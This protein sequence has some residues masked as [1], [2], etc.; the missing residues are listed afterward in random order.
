[1]T[2]CV[3][4]NY[5]T[6]PQE[7]IEVTSQL[8]QEKNKFVIHEELRDIVDFKTFF[9]DVRH[10]LV[11]LGTQRAQQSAGRSVHALRVTLAK[12][13]MPCLQYKE[14]DCTG[15][16][17]MGHFRDSDRP[18]EIFKSLNFPSEFTVHHRR[19]IT[20]IDKIEEKWIAFAKFLNVDQGNPDQDP[21][22]TLH[23]TAVRA[24]KFWTNMFEEHARYWAT[25]PDID[26]HQACRPVYPDGYKYV[27]PRVS[28]TTLEK[29]QAQ[30]SYIKAAKLLHLV[31]HCSQDLVDDHAEFLGDIH[32]DLLQAFKRAAVANDVVSERLNH[33]ATTSPL[34]IMHK[35]DK[36][37]DRTIFNPEAHTKTGD[38]VLL[39]LR[40]DEHAVKG[41]ELARVEKL[42]EME[43]NTGVKRKYMDVMYILPVG[44]HVHTSGPNVGQCS[45][46]GDI[47]DWIVKSFRDWPL[48]RNKKGKMY[49]GQSM[50]D[51]NTVVYS[52]TPT[53]GKRFRK[54]GR[55]FQTMKAQILAMQRRNTLQHQLEIDAY[56]TLADDDI[57]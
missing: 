36:A 34:H 5:I 37:T 23:K 16:H 21:A 31:D 32:T 41:W 42:Y 20:N 7:M 4:A 47:D 3:N 53:R 29:R 18:I 46:W 13:G 48:G 43:D 52:C 55:D 45:D 15:V 24:N 6:L 54:Q 28:F 19:P 56:G 10:D 50:I 51:I 39:D 57:E 22:D 27:T 30:Y 8:F 1:M 44:V 26:D 33:D 12:D 11:G 38:Y 17:W 9:K 49:W 2:G 35:S 40:Q 25:R 14:W